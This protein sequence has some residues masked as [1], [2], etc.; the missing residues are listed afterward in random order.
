MIL[1]IYFYIYI[2][3]YCFFFKV[4]NYPNVTNTTKVHHFYLILNVK[5]YHKL[6]NAQEEKQTKTKKERKETKGSYQRCIQIKK[7][8]T[9]VI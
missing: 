4:N 2:C 5:S 9:G 8:M 1:F 7:Q 6:K 3:N